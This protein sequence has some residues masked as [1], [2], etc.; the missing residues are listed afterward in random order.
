DPEYDRPPILQQYAQRFGADPERWLFLTGERDEVYR[1]IRKD[2][3]LGVEPSVERDLKPGYEVEHSTKSVVVDCR[4]HIPGSFDG[5]GGPLSLLRRRPPAGRPAR[6]GAESATARLAEPPARGER[7]PQRHQRPAAA[8]GLCSHP[9]PL[10]RRPQNVHAPG[11][12]GLGGV[13]G[14]VP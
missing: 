14:V 1:L 9:P 7:R 8:S 13:P 2:F 5:R 12:G 10:D 11:P 3:L 4:G 6:V